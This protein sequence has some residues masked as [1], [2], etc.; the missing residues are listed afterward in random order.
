MS[1]CTLNPSVFTMNVFGIAAGICTRAKKG[2]LERTHN[3]ATSVKS[4][5]TY[6]KLLSFSIIIRISDQLLNLYIV[7]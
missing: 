4:I 7:L 5:Y 2:G 3:L 6:F 1:S